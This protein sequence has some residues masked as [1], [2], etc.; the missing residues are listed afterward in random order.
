MPGKVGT[1]SK[2]NP[3][4]FYLN[5]PDRLFTTVGA[6]TGPKQRPDVVMKY[7]NRK[8]T[9]LKTRIGSAA[10]ALT[11]SQQQMRPGVKVSDKQNYPGAGPRNQQSQGKWDIDGPNKQI[12]ND[13]GKSS[14]NAKPNMRN[15]TECKTVVTNVNCSKQT[16]YST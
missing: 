13:Y 1:V 11:G 5:T 3:D 14:M 8:T 9:E 15:S 2:N 6:S 16:Q 12:P 10:P 4:T 7:T